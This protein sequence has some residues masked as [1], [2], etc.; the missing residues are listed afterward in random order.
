MLVKTYLPQ[1]DRAIATELKSLVDS[2]SSSTTPL[3]LKGAIICDQ[4]KA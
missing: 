3:A 4:I 1:L 2:G